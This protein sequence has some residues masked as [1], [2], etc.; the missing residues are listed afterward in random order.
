MCLLFCCNVLLYYLVVLPFYIMLYITLPRYFALLYGACTL[1]LDIIARA[2]ILY[3]HITCHI[4][5]C[6]HLKWIYFTH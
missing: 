5:W 4:A 3:V 2:T 6:L 1:N